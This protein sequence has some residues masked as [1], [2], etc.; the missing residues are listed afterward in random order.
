MPAARGKRRP[1][2]NTFCSRASPVNCSQ[3]LG[4]NRCRNLGQ[5]HNSILNPLSDRTQL[6]M[7]KCS[8]RPMRSIIEYAEKFYNIVD[9]RINEI[10][11]CLVHE[12]LLLK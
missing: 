1:T 3:W 2:D 12:L 8:C 10:F 6:C 5:E 4:I 9:I 7:V 11:E